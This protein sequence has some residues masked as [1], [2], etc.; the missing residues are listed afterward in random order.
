MGILVKVIKNVAVKHAKNF[1]ANVGSY[2]P[3]LKNAVI[4]K[5]EKKIAD[6]FS[7]TQ[8]GDFNVNPELEALENI[9]FDGIGLGLF[10]N[11]I[12][13]LKYGY[14]AVKI[15]KFK[16]NE[17]LLKYRQEL[18]NNISQQTPRLDLRKGN[19]TADEINSVMKK[20]FIA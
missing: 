5:I 19:I 8:V 2:D 20:I 6:L 15:G 7:S 11:I 14:H 12:D 9:G 16:F 13:I 18:V 3:R 17:V 1:S 4:D 10:D